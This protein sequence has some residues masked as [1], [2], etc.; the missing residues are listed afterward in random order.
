MM[1]KIT[2]LVIITFSMCV[3]LFTTACGQKTTTGKEG[4]SQNSI[5]LTE[6]TAVDGLA[7]SVPSEDLA[8]AAQHMV[9]NMENPI[10]DLSIGPEN[11]QKTA[12][13]VSSPNW[14]Y[15][16]DETNFYYAAKRITDGISIGYL[17]NEDAFAESVK[18]ALGFETCTIVNTQTVENTG[19]KA[20]VGAINYSVNELNN[21][22]V[23]SYSGSVCMIQYEDR[24]YIVVYGMGPEYYSAN[25]ATEL[26][27]TIRYTGAPS[28]MFT[29]TASN[30]PVLICN[31]S[32]QVDTCPAIICVGD[33]TFYCITDEITVSAMDNPT[34]SSM[35]Q[36]DIITYLQQFGDTM[37][38]F[39]VTDKDGHE[40]VCKL[41]YS[42]ENE[43]MYYCGA[44]INNKL[45]VYSATVTSL[46][47]INVLKNG[48]ITLIQSTTVPVANQQV[49]ENS[50]MTEASSEGES[51]SAEMASTAQTIEQ[52]TEQTTPV[53]NEGSMDVEWE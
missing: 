21:L 12:M 28:S 52:S 17:V 49:E 51:E 30:E 50:Q 25:L 1:K 9:N 43:I 38:R 29:P 33:D 13:V 5:E 18:N 41:V 22:E 19:M 48:L 23:Q 37:D 16:T 47:S 6:I 36:N 27:N 40:W 45:Y 42:E 24:Q 4:L 11:P 3:V 2:K 39:L 32:L 35:T 44:Y 20:I 8:Y 46:E 15:Q 10:V 31:N 34:G 7:F 53:N 14:Y 26:I